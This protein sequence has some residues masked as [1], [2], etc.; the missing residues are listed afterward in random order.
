HDA[1]RA[2]GRQALAQRHQLAFAPSAQA[3]LH[4]LRRHPGAPREAL[5]LAES[6][7]LLHAAGEAACVAALF[8]SS[9]CFVDAQATLQALQAH[10]GE[11]DLI[12]LACHAQFRSDNPSFSAL[13]LHDGA[14]SAE[15]AE[16]LRLRPGMVVLSGCE[17]GL[18]GGGGG[19]EMVGL[20]RAFLVAGA[21]RVLASLWPVDDAVTRLFMQAFYGALR[22][23]R[24]PAEALGSAQAAVMRQHPHPFHWAAF[25]LYGG[26]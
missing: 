6:S 15:L 14:L 3:A 9:R 11:A 1:A 10:A 23:G 13:H 17:T 8:T 25:A 20:V 4:G 7:R 22:Q 18:A 24:A 16:T 19:D 21:A 2:P 12:H 5:V 26:W